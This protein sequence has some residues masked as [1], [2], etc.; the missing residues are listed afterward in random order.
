MN[1]NDIYK[2]VKV[3]KI[4]NFRGVFMRDDLPDSP[5]KNECGVINLDSINSGGTHWISYI[6]NN[7]R[8][9]YFDSYGKLRPF[10]T[11]L[12]Y[13]KNCEITYNTKNYQRNHTYNC[14]HLCIKFLLHLIE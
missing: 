2:A 13:M 1:T 12:K 11:F 4:K 9:R 3:L 10:S 14:G 7:H 6:K 8:V 5:K